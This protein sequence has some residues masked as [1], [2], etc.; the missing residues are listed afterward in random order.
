VNFERRSR[1]QALAWGLATTAWRA[2]SILA[3]LD[4]ADQGESGSRG[5]GHRGL[6]TQRDLAGPNRRVR[7]TVS[8]IVADLPAGA[9]CSAGRRLTLNAAILRPG[10]G[11]RGWLARVGWRKLFSSWPEVDANTHRV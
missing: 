5:N 2:D 6:P 1:G 3:F 7:E 10:T 8:R 9:G 4:L 11:G